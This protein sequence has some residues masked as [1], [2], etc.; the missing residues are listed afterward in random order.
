MPESKQFKNKIQV[1][2][3]S[4]AMHNS[5]TITLDHTTINTS[6]YATNNNKKNCQKRFKSI[7]NNNEELVEIAM[8][9][10]END[11]FLVIFFKD[12]NLKN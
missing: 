4:N 10:M 1:F 12:F 2:C 7:N 3:V 6:L 8:R 5:V 9:G 11:N